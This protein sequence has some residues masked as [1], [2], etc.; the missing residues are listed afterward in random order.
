MS[1]PLEKRSEFKSCTRPKTSR[2][3]KGWL[4]ILEVPSNATPNWQAFPTFIRHHGPSKR[5][6]MDKALAYLVSLRLEGKL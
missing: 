6:T 1:H 5:K 4:V 2:G 3:Q